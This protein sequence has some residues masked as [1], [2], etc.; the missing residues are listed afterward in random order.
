[1]N[2]QTY[3]EIII[4]NHIDCWIVELSGRIDL[5]NASKLHNAIKE[6]LN[7]EVQDVILNLNQVSF[8][9]SSGMGVLVSIL[10]SIQ[11]HERHLKLCTLQAN[12]LNI[13]ELLKLDKVFEIYPDCLLAVP[14]KT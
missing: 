9:D 2:S 5:T 12:V 3:L 11:S 7:K 8:I 4:S 1:M 14:T 10:H 6:L 13:F